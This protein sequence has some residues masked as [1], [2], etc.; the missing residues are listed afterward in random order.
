MEDRG[1]KIEEDKNRPSI[2]APRSSILDP[3]SSSFDLVFMDVQMPEMDGLEATACIRAWEARRGGDSPGRRL[4]VVAMTAYAMKG[5]RERCLAAGMDAY[6]SKPIQQ[7]DLLQAL[8]WLL[9]G[10][11]PSDETPVPAESG[12]QL[13]DP[14]V[15]LARVGGDQKLLGELVTLFNRECP[16][17]LADLRAAVA[18]GDAEKVKRTAHTV[19]GSVGIFGARPAFEA[20]QRLEKMGQEGDLAGAAAA[21]DELETLLRRLPPALEVLAAG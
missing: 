1:S 18:A 11:A 7:R 15:A 4:P 20:A 19:K 5:D 10:S 17:W 21:C 16:S 2:L 8:E 6:L 14:A 12:E 13:L 3:R 9:P